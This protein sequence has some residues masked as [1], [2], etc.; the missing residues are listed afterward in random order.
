LNDKFP[1]AK[2]LGYDADSVNFFLELARE[3]YLNP[4]ITEL[5]VKTLRSTRFELVKHGYSISAVDAAMEK[6]ED[7][8][9]Q[10]E[11]DK[12]F[13]LRGE[14][15]FL[16][17]IKQLRD[18]LKTRLERKRGKKFARRRWPLRGYSVKGVEAFCVQLET[19]LSG[20][21]EL[22]LR[23]VRIAV[24]KSSRGGYAEHQVDAFIDKVVEFIQR[25]QVVSS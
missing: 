21:S 14:S 1:R 16:E 17:E 7:V 20:G 2:K 3:Q 12:E 9:A 13:D 25:Q 19:Y 10:R 15:L 22:T 6:L 24:F 23:D 18:L 11:L 8:F 4:A 5:D